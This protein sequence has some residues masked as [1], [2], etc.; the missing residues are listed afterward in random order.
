[1]TPLRVP[2]FEVEA[3]QEPQ[4]RARLRRALEP[5]GRD[6]YQGS[7]ESRPTDGNQFIVPTHA[8]YFGYV[9]AQDRV[10]HPCFRSGH[11]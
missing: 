9:S 5:F 8:Q 6:E 11:Q 7:T 1:M 10:V 3:F 4:G 2:M